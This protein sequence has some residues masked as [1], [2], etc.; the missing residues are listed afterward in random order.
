M[1]GDSLLRSA[2]RWQSFVEALTPSDITVL[3]RAAAG[4]KLKVVCHEQDVSY[5]AIQKRFKRWQQTL[6]LPS[7]VALLYVWR[8]TREQPVGADINEPTLMRHASAIAGE[9]SRRLSRPAQ[10]I[11]VAPERRQ[12]D[13]QHYLVNDSRARRESHRRALARSVL[14]PALWY[15][16]LGVGQDMGPLGLRRVHIPAQHSLFVNTVTATVLQPQ[17]SRAV[18]AL[19]DWAQDI[20]VTS[21]MARIGRAAPFALPIILTARHAGVLEHM[22][23]SGAEI[24]LSQRTTSQALFDWQQIAGACASAAYDSLLDSEFLLAIWPREGRDRELLTMVETLS[25]HLIFG[26]CTGLAL[27]VLAGDTSMPLIALAATEKLRAVVDARLRNAEIL[28]VHP[29]RLLA[30]FSMRDAGLEDDLSLT[31]LATGELLLVDDE[32]RLH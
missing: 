1:S 26:P 5:D 10:R 7:L 11:E 14:S 9:A 23:L 20:D 30:H 13:P 16:L 32:E 6:N 4:Q 31:L 17:Q 2:D 21:Y 29:L 22:A 19:L 25:P 8:T 3:D 28:G 24:A 15:A 27:A 18:L 12:R